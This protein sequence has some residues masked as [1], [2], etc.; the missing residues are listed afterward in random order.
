MPIGTIN[1]KLVNI[2]PTDNELGSYQKHGLRPQDR[3]PN[4]YLRMVARTFS[5]FRDTPANETVVSYISGFESTVNDVII[6]IDVDF[7]QTNINYN[8]FKIQ[9][10]ACMID[11]QLIDIFEDSYYIFSYN[12]FKPSTKF[13]IVIEYDY[14]ERRDNNTARIRFIDYDS[15]K[16]PRLDDK[17]VVSCEYSDQSLDGL[18]ST[19]NFSGR[20]G[21]LIGTFSTS[22][23]GEIIQSN[24]AVPGSK[25]LG[26]DPQ[27]LSKLYIQN[28]KLLF[29]YFGNQSRAIYSSMGMT[30][31]NMLAI[32][33]NQVFRTGDP[34]TSPEEDL[35]SGDMCYFDEDSGK[36][37]R[38]I[39]SRQ[40]YSQIIGLYLNEVNEGNHLIYLS[41]AIHI[42]QIKHNLP[43]DHQLLTMFPG[44]HYFLE[45][46]CSLFDT[47]N[48]I[49]TIGNY[50]L[51]NSS[52][53]I[54]ISHYPGAVRVGY[55]TA[56]NQII[57]NIDHSNEIAAGNILSLFGNFKEYKEEYE[58][59]ELFYDNKEIVRQ[60]NIR[61]RFLTDE[62]DLSY[63]E[64]GNNSVAEVN[65]RCNIYNTSL[66]NE[67]FT[68][69]IYKITSQYFKID[70]PNI[71]SISQYNIDYTNV[72]F[73]SSKLTIN[74]INDISNIINTFSDIYNI[75][76]LLI[77]NL[78]NLNL[79]VADHTTSLSGIISSY[80]LDELS[81]EKEILYLTLK[82]ERFRRGDSWKN[83][84]DSFENFEVVTNI[85]NVY[86][87]ER[88]EIIA[89]IK[90]IKDNQ[91]SQTDN[92][93]NQVQ[94]LINLTT[95]FET[96]TIQLNHINS[97]INIRE[98]RD[99]N[100][101][102]EKTNNELTIISATDT[103]NNA[104]NNI[105]NDSTLKLDIFQ[106][107]DHQRKIFNYTYLTDRLQKRLL[108]IDILSTE[109]VKVQTTYET[110]RLSVDTTIIEE[111]TA[112]NEVNRLKNTISNN[113]LLIKQ[114]TKEYNILRTQL[115]NENLIIEG[116]INFDP[117]DYSDER[118]GTYRYGCDDYE[119]LVGTI[120]TNLITPPC[121]AYTTPDYVVVSKDSNE[122]EID[123][124]LTDGHIDN[125][126]NITLHS[127]DQPRLGSTRLENN[128]VYYTPNPQ[129]VGVD[130]F[131]YSIIDSDGDIVIGTVN[132]AITG[133]YTTYDNINIISGSSLNFLDVLQ[134]DGHTGSQG[135]QIMSITTPSVGII[136]F[137]RG[138]NTFYS[139]DR[140]RGEIL[141]TPPTG[142]QGDLYFDY[143]ITDGTISDVIIDQGTSNETIAQVTDGASITGTCHIIVT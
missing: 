40:K 7:V 140:S 139:A 100:L 93:F 88:E 84:L 52:G 79:I 128:K 10:G 136:S 142:F 92:Y 108:L 13:G 39:A 73:D 30:N 59:N 87:T 20:P 120:A 17:N 127:V 42:D 62:L 82:L 105:R 107:S 27:Y 119:T 135:I 32:T 43:P 99:T 68:R 53:R 89:E 65:S 74:Q 116:D 54:S 118:I 138:D 11:D 76:N 129:V 126:K 23:I 9:A 69:E 18:N 12:D 104:A 85:P 25:V 98:L 122:V 96:T 38:S 109:L 121:G 86:N 22:D 50:V 131:N 143:I 16:F 56:C 61:N 133:P 134:N 2:N 70:N 15:L 106:M 34:V 51:P 49:R 44:S 66:L 137:T 75:R 24:P 115:G 37:K 80:K 112:L 21:L 130:I 55:A 58:A 123:V 33:E 81:T 117:L 57:L 95:M 29:E 8:I 19:T 5:S 3:K 36:Y 83:E 41:G 4:D 35:R 113:N 31:A 97:I 111:V 14:I 132:V 141:F 46:D 78:G 63:L 60:L 114:Y 94:I 103:M 47:Q 91:Q 67:P 26:I 45:D 90:I 71:P 125:T 48:Q 6:P 72:V 1:G 101:L 124:I 28:Y 110:I 77:K 64:L 102:T